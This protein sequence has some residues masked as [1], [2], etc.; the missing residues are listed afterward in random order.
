MIFGKMTLKRNDRAAAESAARAQRDA[1]MI[2]SG[3]I[4][5]QVAR[6]MSKLGIFSY[7]SAADGHTEKEIAEFAGISDYGAKVLLE[8][9]LTAGTISRDGGGRYKLTKTGWFLI[10]DPM[11]RVNMDFNHDVNYKGFWWL[12]D[13]IRSGRP[14]GLK[15]LG[16]WPTI[17][18]GLSSLEPQVQKSWFAFDHFYS[19][20]SFTQALETVFASNPRRI[21]DIGGN[22]GKWAMKCTAYSRDVEV[23]VM[24][25]PQQIGMMK[26][27][28]SDYA[29]KS[30]IHGYPADILNPDTV[31][32]KGFD[33]VWMSQFLD[34]FS[35]E[36]VVD[37]LR[38]ATGALSEKGRIVIME[39]LWDRQQYDTAS[40]DLTQ[41]SLYFTVMANGNSK[42]FSY[43]DLDSYISAA[44]L[45]V[46]AVHD[47]IGFGHSI[48]ECIPE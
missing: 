30:R 5:F 47:G 14:E 21:L 18:E 45:K 37:I 19:D 4:V 34:C 48:L 29:E 39:T 22:T 43:G 42:M 3:A 7:I 12:E 16:N 32:P 1:H 35:A 6:V 10:N 33:I 27:N 8:A 31:F 26:A 2:A 13:A 41:T 25:L 44:G 23:T 40:F 36:Q 46:I 15:E 24:D 17:Y 20:S 28:V 11:V 9:S 38:R